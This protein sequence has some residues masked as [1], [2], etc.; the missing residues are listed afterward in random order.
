MSPKIRCAIFDI[1]PPECCSHFWL[2][3]T[4]ASD[5]PIIAK[6]QQGVESRHVRQRGYNEHVSW[7]FEPIVLIAVSW[8]FGDAVAKE[9]PW[10]VQMLAEVGCVIALLLVAG[11]LWSLFI[12][13]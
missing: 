4:D 8:I 9:K 3:K 5:V 6:W 11:L 10:W 13:L 7:L 12:L 1:A 2:P